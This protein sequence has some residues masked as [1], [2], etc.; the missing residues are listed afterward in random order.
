MPNEGGDAAIAQVLVCNH[1]SMAERVYAEFSD[2]R[3]G[4]YI[5]TEEH[6]NGSLVVIPD[7]TRANLDADKVERDP[8]PPPADQAQ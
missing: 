2:G 4:W 8:S 7:K 5:V 6:P 1:C 3:E